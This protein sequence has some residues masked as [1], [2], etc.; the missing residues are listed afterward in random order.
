MYCR[1]LYLRHE[2]K[3]FSVPW[4]HFILKNEYLREFWNNM[5]KSEVFNNSLFNGIDIVKLEKQSTER[6]LFYPNVV[7]SIFLY[8]SLVETIPGQV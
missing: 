4:M 7:K 3:G 5:E 6:R 2:K 1:P 8:F